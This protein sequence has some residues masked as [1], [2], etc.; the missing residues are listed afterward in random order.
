MQ[1]F[2]PDEMHWLPGFAG[3]KAGLGFLGFDGTEQEGHVMCQG[4]HRLHALCIGSGLSCFTAVSDVP[5][6]RSD[7]RHIHHL[8]RHLQRLESSCC[9]SATTDRYGCARLVLDMDTVAEESALHDSEQGSVRL[10]VINGRTEHKT[11]GI[12]ELGGDGVA[13][14][15]IEDTLAVVIVLAGGT[16]DASADGLIANPNDLRVD[17]FLR[18]SLSYLAQGDVCVAR[19]MGTSVN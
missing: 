16:S 18:Q 14:I 2:L 19:F 13:D 9:A 8:H 4:A 7:E 5:I 1:I 15:V 17:A 11:V 3:W 12:V 6:L 10:T